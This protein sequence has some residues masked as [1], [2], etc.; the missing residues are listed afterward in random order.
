MTSG[1]K[2]RDNLKGGVFGRRTDEDNGAWLYIGEKRILLGLI[3]TV[4]LIN[5]NND[6]K[7]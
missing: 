7:K 5:K 6:P 2:S 1:E 4:Y 3:E